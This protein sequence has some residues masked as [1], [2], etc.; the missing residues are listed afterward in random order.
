MENVSRSTLL[1]EG[2]SFA[3]LLLE[4][5]ISP[6]VVILILFCGNVLINWYDITEMTL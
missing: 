4:G 2:N 3:T 6:T 5:N 1:L